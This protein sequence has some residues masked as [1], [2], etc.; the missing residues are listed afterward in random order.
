MST[1]LILFAIAILI[2]AMILTML[3]YSGQAERKPTPR[4]SAGRRGATSIRQQT[5]W[6]AV[7]IAPGLFAC[8]AAQ[9]LTDRVF[10]AGESPHLPLA[11]CARA[12]CDCKYV[13]LDDRRSGGDRRLDLGSF[14][15][16]L[17]QKQAER[18]YGTD[19]RARGVIA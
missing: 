1:Y 16:Y 5:R 11:S 19:R 3:K 4:P 18:R 10:L 14:G 9:N 13:H 2:V 8:D 12:D 15:A 7:K 17:P 6:R